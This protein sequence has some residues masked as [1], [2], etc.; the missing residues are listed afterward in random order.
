MTEASSLELQA[1]LGLWLEL[2]KGKKE[3]SADFSVVTVLRQTTK[4][5]GATAIQPS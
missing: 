4:Q 2:F 5:T 1:T 3:N